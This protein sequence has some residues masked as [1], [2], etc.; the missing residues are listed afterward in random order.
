MENTPSRVRII[1]K[2][3]NAPGGGNPTLRI[4]VVTVLVLVGI[5]VAW[6]WKGRTMYGRWTRTSQLANAERLA[7]TG[8][9]QA[10]AAAAQ[11][12]LQVDPVNLGATALIADI[13]EKSGA[14]DSVRWRERMVAL[15]PWN[16]T[17]MVNWAQSALRYHDYFTAL[18]A[19]RGFPTNPP[20]PA[21]Y[22][23][24]AGAVALGIG[25]RQQADAHFSEA[26]R[27]DPTNVTRQMNLAKLRLSAEPATARTEARRVLERLADNPAT[28]HD[29]LTVLAKDAL[30]R[31][32]WTVAVRDAQELATR[33]N[34]LVDDQLL[35]LQVLRENG[36]PSFTNQL[37]VAQARASEKPADLASMIVWMNE[38]GSSPQA[39]AWA[40]SLPVEVRKDPRVGIAIADTFIALQDW[41]GLRNWVRSAD[42]GGLN[43]YRIAYDAF[44]TG[45][46]ATPEVRNAEVDGLWVKAVALV[47]D[48]ATQLEALAILADRWRL[49]K[50]AEVTRWA[51]VDSGNGQ[52]NALMTL[53]RLYLAKEDTMGQ[54]RVAQRLFKLK[55]DDLAAQN[56]VVYLGLLLGVADSGLHALADDLHR[57]SPRNP[58]HASTYAFSQHRKG[59]AQAAVDTMAQL[60]P[61][62]L[63]KP[64]MAAIYGVF[65]AKAGD[66]VR[67]REF[68]KLAENTKL[69]PEEEKLVSEA[70]GIAR[71]R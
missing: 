1:R 56:N 10:A 28:R 59:Q 37:H 19:L 5:V 9:L 41:L 12:I 52:E 39:M 24:T 43:S 7:R 65:L 48:D 57:R 58:I 47:K 36:S 55:P 22:H 44:A 15:E 61:S 16:T 30:A 62:I 14:R 50:A 3:A 32:E 49:P 60:E 34:A 11:S 21:F 29:A 63:R 20:P 51:I 64:A 45:F 17:N 68:L 54:Y 67:A 31:K 33:T 25:D 69:L 4:V 38:T 66:T 35:Y 40:R 6:K 71:T 13:A 42:W 27:L 70:R 46:L 18:K 53:H 2:T 26:L 8:R 23:E